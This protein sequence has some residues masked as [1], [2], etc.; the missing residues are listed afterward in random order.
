MQIINIMD[1]SNTINSIETVREKI[2]IF[3]K[4]EKSLKM[5]NVEFRKK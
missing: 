4:G 5:R 2:K 3:R 1:S